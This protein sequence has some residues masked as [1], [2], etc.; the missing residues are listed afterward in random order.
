[1]NKLF[2]DKDGLP[3]ERSQAVDAK[4]CMRS[5][6]SVSVALSMTDSAAPGSILVH[7]TPSKP[8]DAYDG[9]LTRMTRK[10]GQAAADAILAKDEGSAHAGYLARMTARPGQERAA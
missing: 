1:M 3:C 5:G 4:G 7:D 9:Y 10:G 2:Y 8:T 6:Y